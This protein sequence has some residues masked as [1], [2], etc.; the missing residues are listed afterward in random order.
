MLRLPNA[1][2]PLEPL[3]SPLVATQSSLVRRTH[4]QSPGEWSGDGLPLLSFKMVLGGLKWL[5]FDW[6]DSF[7][8]MIVR[9]Y[10]LLLQQSWIVE[11]GRSDLKTTQKCKISSFIGLEIRHSGFG[12][13][14]CQCVEIWHSGFWGIHRWSY[15]LHRDHRK[16]NLSTTLEMFLQCTQ[17]I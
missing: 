12:V 17:I 6:G 14:V 2:R 7:H 16:H 5:S 4:R 10:L 3:T 9:V 11:T 13:C 1:T 8:D 15:F